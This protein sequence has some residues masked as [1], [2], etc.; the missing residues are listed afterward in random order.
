MHRKTR[1][2]GT[3]SSCS[4]AVYREKSVLVINAFPCR[5]RATN[6]PFY[7][8]YHL[9]NY[10]F[11]NHCVSNLRDDKNGGQPFRQRMR[12]TATESTICTTFTR[13]KRTHG[14]KRK[15]RE[16]MKHRVCAIVGIASPRCE[17]FSYFVSYRKFVWRSFPRTGADKL[18]LYH[19]STSHVYFVR[20]LVAISCDSFSTRGPR[21]AFR[22]LTRVHDLSPYL[23]SASD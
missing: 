21:I 16:T 23:P 15:S 4:R 19:G 11:Y 5:K 12:R 3:M 20:V 2:P 14:V 9:A 13:A 17:T 7:R 22:N 6:P 10:I 1:P 18:S 8:S